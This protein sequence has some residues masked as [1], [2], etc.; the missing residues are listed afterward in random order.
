PRDGELGRSPASVDDFSVID[1]H[2]G[3]KGAAPPCRVK[4]QRPLRGLGAEPLAGI[5]LPGQR[6]GVEG[7]SPLVGVWGQRPQR[8]SRQRLD[9]NGIFDT[10]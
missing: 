5:P 9:P 8:G 7:G 10:P 2:L 1:G 3:V 4:G 6:A